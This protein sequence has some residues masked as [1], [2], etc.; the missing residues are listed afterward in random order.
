MPRSWRSA[1]LPGA[2]EDASGNAFCGRAG[3]MLDDLFAGA[4]LSTDEHL[5]IVNV[6]KCRPPRQP[7]AAP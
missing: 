4:G 7:G 3:K 1:K 2:Q 5:L 6:V